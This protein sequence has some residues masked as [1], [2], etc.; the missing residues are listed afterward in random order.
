M[1][2]YDFVS[3]QS[4]S[5]LASPCPS[6]MASACSDPSS[7]CSRWVP[8]LSPLPTVPQVPHIPPLTLT[9][10]M[11]QGFMLIATDLQYEP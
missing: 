3:P 8:P 9:P 11:L 2:C 6:R 5:G 1:P 4:G 10:F 7:H